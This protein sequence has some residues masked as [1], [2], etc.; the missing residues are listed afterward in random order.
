MAEEMD[1]DQLETT[2]EMTF[3]IA[4]FE[5]PSEGG[6]S[7]ASFAPE[8]D[9]SAGKSSKKPLIIS[10]IAIAVLLVA[11]VA[12][13]FTARWYYSSRVAPGVRFGEVSVAGQDREHLTATVKQAVSDSIIIVKDTNGKR[14]NA[15][16]SDLGVSVNVSKTVSNLLNAKSAQNLLQDITRIN[17]FAHEDVS[18]VAQR[19]TYTLTKFL[20]NKLIAEVDRAVPSSISY[21]VN[22]HAF[23]A[24]EGT[25]GKTPES[26]GV[27][28]AIA[29]ALANPGSTTIVT[30][31][32]KQVDTPISIE[33]AKSAAEEANKRLNS[34]I[35]MS[36]GSAKQFDL[37]ME[38]IAKWIQPEG[39]TD[40]GEIVLEYDEAAIKSYMANTLAGKLN[41]D[42]VSQ[43]DIIDDNGA[44]I[45]KAS[46]KGVDEVKVK[47]TDAAASKTIALLK[48]GNGGTVQVETDVKKFDTKQKKS[49]WRAVVNKS[50][51]TASFYKSG[52]LMRTFNVCTGDN[53]NQTANGTWY[54]WQKT[55]KQDISGWE[56]N[57]DNYDILGVTWLSYFTK[58][59]S[60]FHTASWNDTGIATGNPS[61]YGSHGCVNMYEADAQWVYDNCPEGTAVEVVGSQPSGAVR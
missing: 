9:Q 6:G 53:D 52:E 15:S 19:N 24:T 35:T 56:E 26:A 3:S 40:K 43:E 46:T 27:V 13:F 23:V 44:V 4:D 11:L 58:T 34:V 51:Q 14:V 33:N 41:Q 20:S 31:K 21:D 12:S 61:M 48:E 50:T 60:A 25:Q 29:A 22:Q 17:P 42:L 39:D 7:F 54:I 38:E 30:I 10:L 36:N 2:G 32:D 55:A 28:K 1:A 18:F 16:L 37:P 59:G 57:A 47:N 5:V 49:E 8:E 45:V